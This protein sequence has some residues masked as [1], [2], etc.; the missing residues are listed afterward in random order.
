M[1]DPCKV[2]KCK[3][4]QQL[5]KYLDALWHSYCTEEKMTLTVMPKSHQEKPVCD[6]YFFFCNSCNQLVEPG[7]RGRRAQILNLRFPGRN[8]SSMHRF[9]HLILILLKLHLCQQR[10]QSGCFAFR[11]EYCSTKMLLRTS[12]GYHIQLKHVSIIEIYHSASL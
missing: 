9:I 5:W 2:I 12:T 6:L 4:A 10:K 7:P 1:N 3:H 8:L 11:K